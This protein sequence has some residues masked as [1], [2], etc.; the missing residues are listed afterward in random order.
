MLILLKIAVCCLMIFSS[1]SSNLKNLSSFKKESIFSRIIPYNS[2]INLKELKTNENSEN[3]LFLHILFQEIFNKT[4]LSIIFLFFEI[5]PSYIFSMSII[6]KIFIIYLKWIITVYDIQIKMTIELIKVIS[7]VLYYTMGFVILFKLMFNLKKIRNENFSINKQD[8]NYIS[9]YFDYNFDSFLKILSVV[10]IS[11]FASFSTNKN[12]HLL[13]SFYFK[14]EKTFII[15]KIISIIFSITF[16]FIL[17]LIFKK[18]FC[19]EFN[20]ILSA[21]TFL[22]MGID[23]NIT[24]FSIIL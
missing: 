5:K 7:I 6:S 23:E 14:F 24:F 2:S 4:S 18:K 19:F 21:I 22:L 20:L 11:Q 8:E 16:G 10:F 17:S 12:N 3:D 13:N 1:N 15:L 9:W